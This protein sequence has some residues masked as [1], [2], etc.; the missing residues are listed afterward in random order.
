MFDHGM[1]LLRSIWV[2]I[3]FGIVAGAAI[4]IYIPESWLTE[5]AAMGSL[6]A[7]L[8]VLVFS[9]PLYVC[10]TASVPIAA[11]LVMKGVPASAALVFLMAG[12]ASNMATIG[13]IYRSLA[14]PFS[15][16]I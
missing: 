13:A 11:A 12:P 5:M 6:A 7:C 3:V 1:Q 2:W 15:A 10:A 16:S 8:A 4:Q 14:E 9:V